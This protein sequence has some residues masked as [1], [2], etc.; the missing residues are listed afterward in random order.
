VVEGSQQPGW[1]RRVSADERIEY[2]PAAVTHDVQQVD[3]LEKVAWP[4]GVTK[5]SSEP[6][7]ALVSE[8]NRY[9]SKPIVVEDRKLS[10]ES[11]VGAFGI[12]AIPLALS[13]LQKI[14]PIAVTQTDD[15]YVLKY[16][17]DLP[18]Q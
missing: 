10:E 17:S 4:D 9:T 7:S 11:I 18:P 15:S 1:Q 6:L 3:A 14:L 13:R 16:R 5:T 12:D 2:T 8:L